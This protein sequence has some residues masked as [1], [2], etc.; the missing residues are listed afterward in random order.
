M[1][2]IMMNKTKMNQK[3]KNSHRQLRSKV[4]HHMTQKM[5]NKVIQLKTRQDKV[6]TT[7][8]R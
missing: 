4:R 7:K 1:E 5:L 3:L 8:K 2:T 6:K